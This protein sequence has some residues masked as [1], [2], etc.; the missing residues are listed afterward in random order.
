MSNQPTPL[1]P[2]PAPQAPQPRRLSMLAA[3]GIA[4]ATLVAGIGIGYG[5]NDGGTPEPAKT[6][7]VSAHCSE[8]FGNADNIIAA[9][10]DQFVQMGQ[11]LQASGDYSSLGTL[12]D[13]IDATASK[14]RS[15]S[16]SYTAEK[17][18]CLAG[19]Q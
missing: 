9:L 12:V 11:T 17:A 18:Q 16:A 1:P 6:T 3:F 4:A 14:V 8:A 7:P 10:S 2:V 15:E 19:D 13:D 5:L